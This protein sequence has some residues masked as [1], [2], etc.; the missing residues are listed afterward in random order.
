MTLLLSVIALVGLT[1]VIV[2]V[3]FDID[4]KRITKDERNSKGWLNIN[5]KRI[6]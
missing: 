2:E 4:I 3:F 5:G 1:S 6:F